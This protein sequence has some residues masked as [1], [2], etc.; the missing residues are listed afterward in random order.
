MQ[1]GFKRPNA[2]QG[3]LNAFNALFLAT[4]IAFGFN[5]CDKKYVPQNKA[6][7][8]ELVRDESVYLGDIDTSGI[9][10]M[11]ELFAAENCE[12]R[13]QEI[14][15]DYSGIELWDTSSVESMELM[16]S[17]ASH[18][19]KSLNEWDTRN[20]KTMRR[21]FWEATRFNQPL[22]KWDVSGVEDMSG[23]FYQAK[24]FNH[25]L[26]GWN[27]GLVRD[28]SFMF[29]GAEAFN[30]PLNR[31]NVENVED[32]REMFSFAISFNQPLDLWDISKVRD[33]NA[34]FKHARAFS[35]DLGTWG[36]LL[37][38]QTQTHEMFVKSPLFEDKEPKWLK[39]RKRTQRLNFRAKARG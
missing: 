31:W 10:D 37:N 17:G 3:R 24:S 38:A 12:R 28:M 6:E 25:P 4:F 35:Q 13:C 7:L 29:A 22:D 19:N 36:A 21:M 8:K 9:F 30:Q 34:M 32:M 20:V 2:K 1:N 11:S 26:E 23:M 14:R 5:A 18:F 16:F 33:M 39:E 27:V 15:K